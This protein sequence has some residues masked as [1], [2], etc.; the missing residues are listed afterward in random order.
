MS[1]QTEN[2]PQT[3]KTYLFSAT[4]AAAASINVKISQSWKIW[5]PLKTKAELNGFLISPYCLQL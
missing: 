3:Y 5:Y 4:T 1:D 2:T